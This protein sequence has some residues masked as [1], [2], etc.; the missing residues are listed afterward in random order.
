M[1]QLFYQSSRGGFGVPAVEVGRIC[2]KLLGREAGRKCVV[3]DLADKSFVLITGPKE[4]TGVRRRRANVN[5]IEPLQ[6]TVDIK[7]G[8]SD[9]EVTEALKSAG[10]L[11]AMSQPVKPSLG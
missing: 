3:V 5:H 2:V 1:G 8:A 11:E 7:R 4:V 9:E 10:K 6:D